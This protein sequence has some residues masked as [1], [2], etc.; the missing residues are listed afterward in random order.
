MSNNFTPPPLPGGNTGFVPPPLPK[1]KCISTEIIVPLFLLCFLL[2]ILYVLPIIHTNQSKKSTESSSAE[3]EHSYSSSDYDSGKVYTES[4][5]SSKVS[6]NKESSASSDFDNYRFQTGFTS[7]RIPSEEKNSCHNMP[8]KKGKVKIGDCL[9][10]GKDGLGWQIID[11]QNNKALLV[12]HYN[13]SG[14]TN[15]FHTYYNGE[16]KFQTKYSNSLKI[17][18]E[19]SSLRKELEEFYE[20]NFNITEKEQILTTHLINKDNPYNRLDGGNDTEDKLFILDVEEYFKYLSFFNFY[21]DLSE[22]WARNPNRNGTAAITVRNGK[23]YDSYN[24]A[25][26]EAKYVLPACWVKLN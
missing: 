22:F 20:K 14:R 10:F 2:I 9:F 12:G 7:Y 16:N 21:T 1:K 13:Y 19:T 17:T 24:L 5:S 4:S 11:I 26:K 25:W 6:S 23:T 8:L 15:T 3:S 18:W